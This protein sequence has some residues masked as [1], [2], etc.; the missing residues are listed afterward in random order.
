MQFTRLS[1]NSFNES[2]SA[3]FLYRI[4]SKLTHVKR[5]FL[6]VNMFFKSR[7]CDRLVLRSHFNLGK[8]THF[9]CA[10]LAE[11]PLE[12]YLLLYYLLYLFNIFILFCLILIYLDKNILLEYIARHLHSFIILNMSRRNF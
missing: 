6:L 4:P 12:K 9:L 5:F 10:I 11:I 8:L 7:G 1:E 2:F 3:Y